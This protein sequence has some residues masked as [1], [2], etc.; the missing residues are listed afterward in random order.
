MKVKF[1]QKVYGVDGT[2][3][4]A[5]KGRDLT[6]KDV[7]ISSIL[8][9][10]GTRPDEDTDEKKYHRFQIYKK[11]KDGKD[12]VDLTANEIVDLKKAIGKHQPSLVM[13]QCWDYLEQK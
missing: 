13:G 4:K 6:L 3:L 12:E 2:P 5:D 7:C 11:I 8:G 9:P 1:N 10:A